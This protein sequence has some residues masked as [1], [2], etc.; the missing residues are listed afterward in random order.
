M[1]V[2]DERK[3]LHVSI[4]RG[5]AARTRHREP[6]VMIWAHISTAVVESAYLPEPTGPCSFLAEAFH[7][8]RR[9][10]E[11]HLF[12]GPFAEAAPPSPVNTLA[13][14][15]IRSSQPIRMCI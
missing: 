14:D 8:S 12:V 3:P 6:D 5:R 13:F 2:N 15:F 10:N 7:L 9:G 4:D 1:R 11:N